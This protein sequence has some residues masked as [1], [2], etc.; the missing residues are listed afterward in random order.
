MPNLNNMN[1]SNPGIKFYVDDPE[2]VIQKKIRKT[3]II[4]V[5]AILLTCLVI[6]LAIFE[7]KKYAS[8]MS[9]KEDLIKSQLQI[10][11]LNDNTLKNWQAIEPY[12]D[13]IIEAL[14]DQTNLLKYQSA[15][16]E[17]AS[18]AGVQISVNI[19]ASAQK[20]PVNLPQSSGSVNPNALKTVNGLD[21]TVEVK[22]SFANFRNFLKNIENLPYYVLVN[23][24]SINSSGGIDQEASINLSLKIFN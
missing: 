20:A 16:E 7:I 3:Y 9:Q 22:G 21:H 1:I 19:A 6:L 8:Q 24:F 2:K 18:S 17:A 10:G 15:L 12:K 4:I 11:N 13:Q 5:V 23:N 14:P